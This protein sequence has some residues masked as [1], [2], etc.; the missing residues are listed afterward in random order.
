MKK[1]I[2]IICLLMFS[3]LLVACGSSTKG[4]NNGNVTEPQKKSIYKEAGAQKIVIY[5]RT[6]EEWHQKWL[7]NLVNDFNADLT[8]GIQV[9]VKFYTEDT[10]PDALVV[11]RENGKAPDIF[12]STYGDLYTNYNNNWCAPIE[13]YLTDAQK[14]DF[15]EGALNMVSYGGHMMAYPWN[16]EPGSLLFY[17][18]DLLES[19]GVTSVPKTWDELY[20]ACEKIKPN[21][22]RGKYCLGV[23][24][25]QIECSWV[26]YGL[27][28]N[29]TGG[30]ALNDDWSETRID[31]EGYKDIAEFFYTL[32]KNGYSPIAGITDEGYTDIVE[33]LCD[34]K[35]AMTFAGSWSVSYIY[36]YLTEEEDKKIIDQIG[37]APIP[38]KEGKQDIATSSNGGWC[39]CISQASK[40][41]DMAAKVLNYMFAQSPEITAQYFI[42]AYNSKSPTSKSVKD[43]LDT[44]TVVTPAEWIQVINDVASKG[45]PE[46]IYPWD[47]ASEVGGIFATMEL[48]AK[49]DTF[50]SLYAKALLTAKSNIATVMSR[51]NFPKNPRLTEKE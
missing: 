31:H 9:E 6:F 44:I 21:L 19:A 32:Y 42:A 36:D 5:T 25:G 15:F 24:L 28:M 13:E 10:Y 18:K 11:A 23:P 40:H 48:N 17:R 27:Q 39:Y 12:I 46:A 35:V 50:E 51:S 2:T 30:L 47:I 14:E 8:D 41:K 37:V 33:A 34:G 22:S 29:T 4:T 26:S 45:F 49:T 7:S 3:L 43:Y 38:T 20:A 1:F 16:L